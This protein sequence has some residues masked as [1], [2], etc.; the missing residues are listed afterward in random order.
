MLTGD[1]SGQL[2]LWDVLSGQV[3]RALLPSGG[4]PIQRIAPGPA[5]PG[6]YLLEFQSGPAAVG[7]VQ[8]DGTVLTTPLPL[9]GGDPGEEAEEK[10][11]RQSPP[12]ETGPGSREA[13]TKVPGQAAVVGAGG[14][15]IVAASR[16][17]LLVLR[18]ADL[19]IV[20][21]IRV[22]RCMLECKC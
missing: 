3:L 17:V 16:G 22:R 15:V 14:R 21:A 13:A 9:P 11:L 5:G 1:E 7:Q 10:P 6:Q 19:A 20:D 4:R 2:L 18:P 8:A 12:P